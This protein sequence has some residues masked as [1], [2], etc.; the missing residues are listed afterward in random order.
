MECRHIFFIFEKG[1]NILPEKQSNSM[2]IRACYKTC[3]VDVLALSQSNNCDT[4]SASWNMSRELLIDGPYA[5]RGC[6][7]RLGGGF[8]A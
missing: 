7:P 2:T 8:A 5:L 3:G 4:S 6:P 1:Y